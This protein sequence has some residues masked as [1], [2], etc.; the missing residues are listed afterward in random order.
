MKIKVEDASKAQKLIK[1]EVEPQR[2]DAALNEVYDSIKKNASVPGYRPG[3]VPMDLLKA[4]YNKRASEEAVNSLIWQCYE[5]AVS[6]QGIK[7]LGYPVVQDVNYTENKNLSFSVRVDVSPEFKLKQYK[8]IK[9]SQKPCQVTDEDIDKAM[10]QIQESMAQYKDIAPRPIKNGDY[11][12]C[13]YECFENGKLVD[14]KDKLWL[15]I[16]DKLQPKELLQALLG[17][18]IDTEKQALVKYPEDY[19]YKELAGRQRL[20]KITPK[21]IKEKILPEIDDEF[22]KK[23][24][25]FTSIADLKKFV[26]DN[27]AASKKAESERDIERQIY[28]YLLKSHDFDTPDSFVQRQLDALLRQAKQRLFYQGYKKEDVDGLDNKLKESLRD[29]AERDVRLFFI[30]DRISKEESISAQDEDIRQRIAE[31]AEEAKEDV[32]KTGKRLESDGL[33]E[34]LKEQ[35]AHDKTVRFLINESKG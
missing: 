14:K 4:H 7:V 9:V 33:M 1:I 18:D 26:S 2:V 27:A 25:N 3:R 10:G 19:E 21:Q 5:Q 28:D 31:I 11:I 24:G 29:Q 13:L 34:G 6:G 16:N 17:A 8:G 23:A 15:Y 30:I 22:A 20:Y 12:V 32:E 35:I